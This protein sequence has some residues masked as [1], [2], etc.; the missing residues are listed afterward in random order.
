M[1]LFLFFC[2]GATALIYEVLWSKYL[3]LLFGSTIQAQTVVLAVFMGGLAA[4]NKIFSRRADQTV[5]PLK[6]YG[7]IEITVGIYA[8]L[9]PAVYWLADKI[10]V[11]TGAKILMHSG[12]LLLLKGILSVALLAAPTILMGGTLPVLAV[13]LKRNAADAGRR[14]ARFYSTNTFGAVCGAGLAGFYLIP[15]FGMSFA[16]NCAAAVNVLIGLTA[17]VRAGKQIQPAPMGRMS[18]RAERKKNQKSAK[19]RSAELVNESPLKLL[20]WACAIVALTGAVSMGSEILASRCLALIFGSSL[21]AF[22]IVLMAFILGIGVGGAVIASPR[23]SRWSKKAAT[24]FL[25]LA[26]AIFIG[27]VVFNFVNLM[28]TYRRIKSGLSSDAAGWQNY[29]L[30]ILT[31]SICILGLPAA[32][33]GAVLPLWIRIVSETSDLLGDRVG[34]LLTWNTLGAVFGILVTGFVLM[35]QIGLRASFATLALVSTAAA[36]FTAFATGQKFG[37]AVGIAVAPFLIF[38]S[39]TGGDGWR[40]ALTAGAFRVHETPPLIPISERAKE[41]KLIFYKDAAD[42]TISVERDEDSELVLRING[43]GDASSHGD[44][45]TQIL[46]GQLPL[47]MKPDAKDIFCFGLGSGITAGTTLGWP[48]EHLAVAEN[49]KPVLAAAKLFA[50]WNNGVLANNRVHIFDEDARTVLKLNPQKYDAI[51]AEPSNPWM[52][53]VGSVFSEEFYRLTASRLKP[54]GIMTQWFHTYEVD[55]ATFNLVLR[56]FAKV[57]PAMEIWDAGGGDVILL[58]SDRPW[59]SDPQIYRSAFELPQP[60]HD[61]EAIGLKTPRDVW[62]RQL[63]S[64]ETAFAIADA[65]PVQRDNFPI[66]E[67][68]APRAMFIDAGL[69]AEGIQRFDE[70]TWQWHIAPP[71]KN[72][73]LSQLDSEDLENI[74]REF[75]SVDPG[76]QQFVRARVEGTLADSQLCSLPCIFHGTNAT[77]VF[78][79]PDAPAVFKQLANADAELENSSAGQTQAV[80]QIK[81]ILDSLQNYDRRRDGWSAGYY[82]YVAAETCFRSGNPAEARTILSRGL[83]LEPDSEE[84]NYLWRILARDGTVR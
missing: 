64:Q 21:Q 13:W 61:L 9:F 4:G 16:M 46:L 29:Q 55:D 65:G 68:A 69:Q 8:F 25:L 81:I 51:I 60:R 19:G 38:V 14:S 76:L 44:L 10:F 70:R 18:P 23:F 63:A 24:V 3:A 57:F 59:K 6:I 79:L 50:S 41:T 31:A 84:L 49:C 11:F 66:L 2:S 39:A 67:Y 37:A 12:W 77:A 32:A 78:Y 48:I 17:I 33:L 56:T 1:I 15:D 45:S 40:Y 34:R 36:I 74:F 5:R 22:S 53:N 30:F 28:E 35:P 42:A 43:K 27:L 82:A 62:A 71:E 20:R 58:G 72:R 73:V 52:V 80:Y 83:Q 26:A 47:M 54:G 7:G 75:P